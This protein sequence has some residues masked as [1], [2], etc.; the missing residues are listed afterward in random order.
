[1]G[2]VSAMALRGRDGA[3]LRPKSSSGL[4]AP[5]Y[6]VVSSWGR[7]GGPEVWR[8]AWPPG[9]A[10]HPPARALPPLPG[11]RRDWD[12]SVTE[13]EVTQPRGWRQAHAS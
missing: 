2:L 8:G 5:E 4:V 1:M 12:A 11:V 7:G 13:R 6:C 3:G 9:A 10:P